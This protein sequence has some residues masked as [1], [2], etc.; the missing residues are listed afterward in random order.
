MTTANMIHHR[1]L[2]LFTNVLAVL[3]IFNSR[4]KQNEEKA[5]SA[6]TSEAPSERPSM[7]QVRSAEETV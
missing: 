6:T 2:F 3:D 7:V 5:R 1:A 4:A